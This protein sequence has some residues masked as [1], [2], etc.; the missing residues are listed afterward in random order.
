MAHLLPLRGN[1]V[2]VLNVN[3]ASRV[4]HF[5]G[6]DTMKKMKALIRTAV[7]PLLI[8]L[9]AISTN[10]L[11][12]DEVT[13]TG[14][15]NAYFQIETEDGELYDIAVTSIGDE[16]MRLVGARIEATGIVQETEGNKVI[17]VTSY[18]ILAEDPKEGA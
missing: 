15:V 16:L 6:G 2:D 1:D 18:Q 10:A 3:R 11:P 13:I 14:R 8:L 9:S 5:Q 7:F 12:N 17:V 4:Q